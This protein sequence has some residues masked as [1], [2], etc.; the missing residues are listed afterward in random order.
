LGTSKLGHGDSYSPIER[1]PI[2]R[3]IGAMRF[4]QIDLKIGTID[5]HNG[6]EAQLLF[7]RNVRDVRMTA[8][9]AERYAYELLDVV[10]ELRK[11]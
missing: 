8:N 5:E 2:R 1:H 7:S 6:P 4:E 3:I 9:E 11:L 10:K